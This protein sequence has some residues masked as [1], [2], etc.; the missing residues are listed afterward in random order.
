MEPEDLLIS[1]DVVS[2]FTMVP[3]MESIELLSQLFSKDI[4]D[5]FRTCLTTSY[6]LW[7]GEFYEQTDGVAM[8]SPLS[9]V[10]ANFFMEKFEHHIL[11]TAPLKPKVWFRY[12]DDTFVI[13]SHCKEELNIFLKHINS[14]NRNIQFTMEMEQDG[15][16]P[17]LDVLVIREG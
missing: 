3:I 1:F 11:D 10:I 5:L 9:P 7:D 2:L 6:F 17:L 13:W 14:V 4:L 8:G 15:K 12:M 16:L